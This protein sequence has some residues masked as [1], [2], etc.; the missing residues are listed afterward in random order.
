[1]KVFY[2]ESHLESNSSVSQR[3]KL[4][5]LDANCYTEGVSLGNGDLSSTGAWDSGNDR[6]SLNEM[7]GQTFFFLKFVYFEGERTRVYT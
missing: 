1:M 6:E 3:R 7:E 2:P 5:C 4:T